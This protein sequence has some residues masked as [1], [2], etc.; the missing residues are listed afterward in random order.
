MNITPELLPALSCGAA[1]LGSGGGQNPKVLLQH[2]ESALKSCGPVSLI[3]VDSLEDSA[4]IA[5]VEYMG[6]PDPTIPLVLEGRDIEILIKRVERRFSKNVDAILT[7]EIGGANGLV[8]VLV[9]ARLGLPLIDGDNVGRALPRLEM[10]TP[11]LF[12]IQPT[13]AFFAAENGATIVEIDTPDV[14]SLE[15]MCRSLS[16]SFGGNAAF[17]YN[18][19]KGREAKI[20]IARNTVSQAVSWGKKMLSSQKLG[21]ILSQGTINRVKLDRQ[22]GFLKGTIEIQTHQSILTIEV[23]NEFM[24]VHSDSKVLACVPDII[25]LIKDD[26]TILTS[27]S[28]TSGMTVTLHHLDAPPIW[29]KDKGIKVLKE[30]GFI[31]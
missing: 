3:D 31:T 4:L 19:M 5:P 2:V 28:V 6:A 12:G 30:A 23:C 7:G 9:A 11:S 15:T 20:A 16:T 8:G 22:S 10:N 27:D 14:S 24:S 21:T 18:I 29:L 25:A 17:I 1:L 26:Q 13:P